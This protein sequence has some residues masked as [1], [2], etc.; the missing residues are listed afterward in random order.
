M[1][2]EKDKT[3]IRPFIKSDRKRLALYAN[4]KNVQQNLRD[5]MPFPYSV[6]DADL[7]IATVLMESPV[8]T[9]AIL[10]QKKLVGVCGLILQ[11]DIYRKS[12]EVGYWVAEPYW[13]KGIASAALKLVTNYAF[14]RLDKRRVY[15]GV[16]EYNVASMKVLENCGYTKEGVFSK[17]LIKDGKFYD[18]VRYARVR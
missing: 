17:A 14:E 13:G 7:F 3:A 16:F 4:N 10:F 5:S 6:E 8:H 1:K 18:E 2:L 11:E 15:T 12:C 9:F